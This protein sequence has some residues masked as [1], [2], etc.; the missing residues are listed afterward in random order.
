[1]PTTSFAALVTDW[2]QLLTKVSANATDPTFLED[3]R[4]ALATT[5]E[6]AKDTS[7]RRS[8]FR[9]RNGIRT[10][11]GLKAEKLAELNLRPRRPGQKAKHTP[12]PVPAPPAATKE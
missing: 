3:S 6:S 8:T 12:T 11:Y 7:T 9:L 4:A 10:R 1:M 2:E 5:L